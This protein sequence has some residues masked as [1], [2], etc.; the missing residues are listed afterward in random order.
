MALNEFNLAG[1]NVDISD[2]GVRLWSKKNGYH[3]AVL[4]KHDDFNRIA[5]MVGN[6]QKENKGDDN[7]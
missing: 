3:E 5:R 1:T 6:W 4:I 2:E 7:A